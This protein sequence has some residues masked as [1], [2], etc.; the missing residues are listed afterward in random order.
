MRVA[1]V[2]TDGDAYGLTVTTD[3]SWNLLF[4][5]QPIGTVSEYKLGPIYDNSFELI[6]ARDTSLPAEI[7]FERNIQVG[8]LYT[9]VVSGRANNGTLDVFHIA[10]SAER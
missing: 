4:P 10:E 5:N 1:N 3:G 2:A 7:A 9:F 6:P 8:L